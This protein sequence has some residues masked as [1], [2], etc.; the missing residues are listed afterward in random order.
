MNTVSIQIDAQ[1]KTHFNHLI[2][3]KNDCLSN[4]ELTKA[5]EKINHI[6]VTNKDPY[7]LEQMAGLESM[8]AMVDD[9]TWTV[10]SENA[11]LINATIRYVANDSDLI[12]DHIPGI[13]YLDDCIVI[14]NTLDA[15]EQELS[16]FKD[17]SRTRMVYAK[18]KQFT[19]SD[20][21]KIKDQ[22]TAS[23]IRNRRQKRSRL[24]QQW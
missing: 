21:H 13:G 22:E 15:V 20:W 4:I 2:S 7:I 11:K 3:E 9:N 6:R 10:S 24:T 23:R 14:D 18:N 1:V 5:S 8:I 17:F 16:E 19:L 12:P